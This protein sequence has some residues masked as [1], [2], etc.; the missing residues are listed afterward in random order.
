MIFNGGTISPRQLEASREFYRNPEVQKR[1][2]E[3]CGGEKFTCEYMVGF[4]E[5]LA[6][7]GYHRPIQ[8]VTSIKEF[9][10][11]MENGLDLFRAVWDRKATLAVWDIEYFNLDTWLGLYRNQETYFELMEPSYLAIEELLG[12]YGI[13][14]INDTTSSGYHLVSLIPFNSLVHRRLE[15]IG[16]IEPTLEDKYALKAKKD[17]KRNRATPKKAALGYSGIGRL[18]E[19]LSHKVIQRTRQTSPIPVTIS[20]AAVR[21]KN[22]GREGMSMDITQ[23]AD[24]LFMRDIR[25]TFSTH[26]K[27]KVYIGR[28]GRDLATRMPL[29][30]TLPRNKLSHQELFSLRRDLGKAAEYA[31]EC[32]GI[33]PDASAGWQRLISDY[34]KSRLFRFHRDFDSVEHYQRRRWKKQ[35]LSLDLSNLPPCVAHPIRNANWSLLIPTNLQNICRVLYAIGW[36]PKHIGGMI[37]AHYELDL[38]WNTD[39]NKYDPSSRANFWARIY[40]GMIYAGTDTLEDFSCEAHQERGFCPCNWCGFRLKDYRNRLER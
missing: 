27:H 18:H 25:T 6:K 7:K 4:G 14:H 13:E 39:W 37:R 12:E 1:I 31:A 38:N 16:C 17:H 24:P 15:R 32:S 21:R 11:L 28:V 36:H 33:I 23:Y 2:H 26:Q 8:L 9:H 3:F 10:G 20:D 22:R 19:Y 34:R 5:T 35:Y 29:Y 40:C 30:A